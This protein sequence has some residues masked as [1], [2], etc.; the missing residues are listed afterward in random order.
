MADNNRKGNG[1]NNRRSYNGKGKNGN[2]KRK[3]KERELN[4]KPASD[5]KKDVPED[6]MLDQE[7][8]KNRALSRTYHEKG[9]EGQMQMLENL[10]KEIAAYDA[11]AVDMIADGVAW[12][13]PSKGETTFD[14][15]NKMY[16]RLLLEQ[17]VRPIIMGRATEEAVWQAAGVMIAG[18]ITNK[19][20]RDSV[21]KGA[22][23]VIEP[24]VKRKSAEAGP[25]S[26]WRKWE[27]KV[28]ECEND[29]RLPLCPRNAAMMQLGLD[30]RYYREM[31]EPGA[32][33][34]KLFKA[35]MDNRQ[36][37]YKL[38]ERDGISEAELNQNVRTLVGQMQ[39]V[40]PT[41]SKMYMET[42]FDSVRKAPGVYDKDKDMTFWAG[43]F[44]DKAGNPYT[45]SFS[46][47][48]PTKSYQWARTLDASMED[49]FKRCKTA[50]DVM[51]LGDVISGGKAPHGKEWMDTW[52]ARNNRDF[53]VMHDDCITPDDFEKLD[54]FTESFASTHMQGWL[55]SHPKEAEEIRK[56][57]AARQTEDERDVHY[58]NGM[59][60]ESP[61]DTPRYPDGSPIPKE[62]QVMLPDT[63]K[64]QE[65]G[66]DVTYGG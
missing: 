45:G 36:K 34:N 28:L 17:A 44:T 32:D 38:C 24:Y 16:S 31:R 4:R 9:S 46:V 60:T 57:W 41:V 30:R 53:D 43:E 63:M 35:Y 39:G 11:K 29:G 23:K 51:D 61:D 42:A 20:F 50:Q 1:G 14:A 6:T 56:R 54:R 26:K 64:E 18:Y 58:G 25:D 21:N 66:F 19:E 55:N 49:A 59:D 52:M 13:D 33:S 15:M 2:G 40:D 48:T 3:P 8:I 65:P 12:Q 62:R 10:Q 7:A 47:R 22:C 27:E 5:S 37:L